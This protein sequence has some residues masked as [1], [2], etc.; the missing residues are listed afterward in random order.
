MSG[1]KGY[2]VEIAAEVRRARAEAAARARCD[3]L[4]RRRDEVSRRVVAL[5]A[6]AS[7]RRTSDLTRMGLE[8]LEVLERDLSGEIQALVDAESRA[9]AD[10]VRRQLAETFEQLGEITGVVP[11]MHA[12][13]ARAARPTV[14]ADGVL[15]SLTRCLDR[16]AHLDQPTREEL[17]DDVAVVR[18][19]LD[20]GQAVQADALLMSLQTRSER[21]ARAQRERERVARQAELLGIRAADLPGPLGQD[22]RARAER[23]TT[24]EELAAVEELERQVRVQLS[25][26]EDRR[27][28]VL[29]TQ[30]ALRELGYEVGEEMLDLA[31]VAPVVVHRPDLPDHAVEISF[32][33]QA[34]RVLTRVVA[35]GETTPQRDVEAEEITCQDLLALGEMWADR[36]V[37]AE[38]YSHAEPGQVAVKRV[39]EGRTRT[40]RRATRE[41]GLP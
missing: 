16:V 25:R 1:P 20:E 8:K 22:V 12:A 13:P 9:T 15:E 35:L 17:T 4:R 24:K 27:F 11:T 31:G 32:A 19:L 21:A 29:Q 10:I 26:E 39:Q 30:A 33:A 7:P 36:G 6:Q 3:E 37:R 41:R 34:P 2:S 38:L 28:I 5:G 14:D 18:R 40:A 23:C